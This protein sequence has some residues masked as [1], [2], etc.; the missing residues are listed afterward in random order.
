MEHKLSLPTL[1]GFEFAVG[2]LFLFGLIKKVMPQPGP[3]KK[4]D[5]S[6]KGNSQEVEQKDAG[7]AAEYF[8]FDF[9]SDEY[10]NGGAWDAQQKSG[11]K[12]SEGEE[13]GAI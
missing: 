9:H 3:Y 6:A 12:V 7:D 2:G 1:I 11:G 13:S 10:L 8:A 4:A 5:Q